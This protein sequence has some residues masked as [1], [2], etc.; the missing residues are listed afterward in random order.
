MDFFV[1]LH[2]NPKNERMSRIFDFEST[3]IYNSTINRL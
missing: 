3:E 2:I 1:R